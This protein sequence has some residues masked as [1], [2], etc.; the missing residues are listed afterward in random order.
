MY[1]YRCFTAALSRLLCAPP[2]SLA[3]HLSCFSRLTFGPFFSLPPCCFLLSVCPAAP[4]INGFF[5]GRVSELHRS[6]F[7]PFSHVTR[8]SSPPLPLL[9]NPH[10]LFSVTF[11]LF[12]LLLSLLIVPLPVPLNVTICVPCLN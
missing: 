11:N 6:N 1:L 2:S 12:S 3:L 5:T 8:F 10:D 9:N 4:T 7:L